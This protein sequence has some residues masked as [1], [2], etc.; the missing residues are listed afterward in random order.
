MDGRVLREA[1]A[2]AHEQPTV[3]EK[4]I[5]TQRDVGD[6]VWRQHLRT[7]TVDGVTYFLNGNGSPKSN[8]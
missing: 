2:G 7:A 3:E 4:T 5:E 6:R 8:L 1:L